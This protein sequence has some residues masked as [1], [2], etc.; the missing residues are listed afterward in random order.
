[1]RHSFYFLQT[2][3]DKKPKILLLK[4]V[5]E[6]TLIVHAVITF[7]SSMTGVRNVKEFK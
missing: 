2:V 1:M 4:C 6:Y 5:C 3:T 7:W